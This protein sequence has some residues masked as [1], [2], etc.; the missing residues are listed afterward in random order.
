LFGLTIP[1]FFIIIVYYL[2]R[3]LI[4]G[5][6]ATA[7]QTETRIS[8]GEPFT[9]YK[10]RVLGR[11]EHWE[12]QSI[13]DA[14]DDNTTTWLGNLLLRVYLD[15]LPQLFNVLVGDMR[16]VGPRPWEVTGAKNELKNTGLRRKYLSRAGLTGPDQLQ[17]GFSDRHDKWEGDYRYL[18]LQYHGGRLKRLRVDIIMIA[19]TVVPVLK[20]EGE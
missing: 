12:G 5:G 4:I 1:I 10:F 14:E 9:L 3:S 13:K 8:D 16:L 2:I 15:E 17:K 20:S 7:F 6:P 19:Q 18:Y 11:P